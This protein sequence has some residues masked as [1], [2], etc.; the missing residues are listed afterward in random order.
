MLKIGRHVL[1]VS[2]NVCTRAETFARDGDRFVAQIR[3]KM[4]V[5]A[6]TGAAHICAKKHCQA[7]SV[8]TNIGHT[9]KNMPTNFDS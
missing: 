5:P 2:F 8:A 3:A 1:W 6:G 9:S 7:K 4:C